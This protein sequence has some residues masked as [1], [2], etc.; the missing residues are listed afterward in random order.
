MSV[1]AVVFD[2]GGTLTP[3]HTIDLLDLWRVAADVLAPGDPARAEEIAVALA[4]AERRWWDHVG[5]TGRSG[6][7]ADVLAAAG[8]E[9]GFDLDAALHDAA[10]EAHLDAWTPHTITYPE[11]TPLL[12]ALRERGIRTGLL[13]NTHW[14]RA[15][16]ER[17]LERDGVLDLFDAR[18]YTSDLE[19]TKPHPAAFHAVLDQLG[20][21]P[22]A[23]VFVGD[24]P[25]DDI[26]GAKALGMRAVLVPGAD[27]PDHPVL[28]DAQIARLSQLLP[29]ID[30]W[31]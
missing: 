25:V 24:R 14:P 8:R 3:F 13:S 12:L 7:T 30:E 1:D 22:E 23:A 29:L 17:W 5:A 21:L 31:R 2:W 9:T 6:T 26:S 4:A 27:A 20:V 19:H 18:V 28:P 11:A 15:W 10:V 16:H